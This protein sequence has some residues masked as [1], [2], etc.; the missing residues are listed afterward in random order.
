MD[1]GDLTGDAQLRRLAYPSIQASVFRSRYE[2]II[3]EVVPFPGRNSKLLLQRCK[4]H[5]ESV[6]PEF[7]FRWECAHGSCLVLP[8]DAGC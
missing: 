5:S 2:A 4:V 3:E 8:R 7:P 6:V 1:G